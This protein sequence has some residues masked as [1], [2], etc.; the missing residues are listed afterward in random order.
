LIVNGVIIFLFMQIKVLFL[1]EIDDAMER[2]LI[3]F[4][5]TVFNNPMKRW[6]LLV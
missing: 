6:H 5:S 4:N 1:S 3:K 2:G